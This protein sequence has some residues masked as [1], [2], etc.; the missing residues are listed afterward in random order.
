MATAPGRAIQPWQ[1]QPKLPLATDT[2]SC[3]S[4]PVNPKIPRQTGAKGLVSQLDARIGPKALLLRVL[5]R[6]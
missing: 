1:A 5:S 2:T 6:L 4:C 3:S